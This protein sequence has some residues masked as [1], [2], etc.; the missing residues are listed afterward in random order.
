MM[1]WVN[2]IQEVD[3]FDSKMCLNFQLIMAMNILGEELQLLARVSLKDVTFLKTY[4]IFEKNIS[5]SSYYKQLIVVASILHLGG[6][7]S[8]ESLWSSR[9]VGR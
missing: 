8:L 9:V 2:Q 3:R 5:R 1:R 7:D 6:L 4:Y